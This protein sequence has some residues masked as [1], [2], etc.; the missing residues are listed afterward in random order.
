L[1]D[2]TQDTRTRPRFYGFVLALVATLALTLAACGGGSTQGGGASTGTGDD[3][4]STTPME[5]SGGDGY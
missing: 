3:G 2:M 4:M 1:L 5:S